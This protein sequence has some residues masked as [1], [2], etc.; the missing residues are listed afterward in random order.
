MEKHVEQNCRKRLEWGDQRSF[1]I[2]HLSGP[3]SRKHVEHEGVGSI[4]ALEMSM[5]KYSH[6]NT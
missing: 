5:L 6:S 3:Q 2:K 1:C 4:G